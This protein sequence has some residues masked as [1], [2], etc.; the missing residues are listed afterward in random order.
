MQY[1][2]SLVHLVHASLT[3]VLLSVS[4]VAGQEEVPGDSAG[5]E[6]HPS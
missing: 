3:A 4:C 2:N 6:R 5:E 1:I